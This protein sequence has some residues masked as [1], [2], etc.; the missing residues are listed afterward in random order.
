MIDRDWEGRRAY[1]VLS[2]AAAVVL[3]FF[4]IFF[5]KHRLL[6]MYCSALLSTWPA[7]FFLPSSF[8]SH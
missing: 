8:I 7:C 6:G 4:K 5:I 1:H 2:K 3:L